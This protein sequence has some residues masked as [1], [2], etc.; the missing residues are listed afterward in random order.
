[1]DPQNVLSLRLFVN[2]KWLFVKPANRMDTFQS[3]GF[4]C[5]CQQ[6]FLN[7]DVVAPPLHFP[8]VP[9]PH[10]TN[11]PLFS[12][13]FKSETFSPLS[14][15]YFTSGNDVLPFGSG[16]SSFNFIQFIAAVEPKRCYKFLSSSLKSTQATVQN[17]KHGVSSF[18]PKQCCNHMLNVN[19][20]CSLFK[21]LSLIHTVMKHATEL[22]K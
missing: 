14:L 3:G 15:N 6:L 22:K 19:R 11:I 5:E 4:M 2:H 18:L 12:G 21:H 9:H 13:W 17:L 7:A 10:V 8:H 1:M 20:S 16:A